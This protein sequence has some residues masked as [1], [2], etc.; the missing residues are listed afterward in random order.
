MFMQRTRRFGLLAAVIPTLLTLVFMTGCSRDPNVRKQKYL[1]SGKRYEDAGKLKEAQI[2]FL[3]ALKVDHNFGD[4]HYELAKIYLKTGSIKEGYGELM[5]AVDLSPGNLQARIDLGNLLLAGNVLDRANQ[6]A[7]AVLAADPNNAD[8]YA[9]RSAIDARQG[10]HA[11][12][13]ADIQHALSIKPNQASYHTTLALIEASDP[14]AG[15]L[16]SAQQELQKS[17][18]LDPKDVHARM[19][20]ASLMEKKGDKAGAEQQYL[21]TIQVTPKDYQ[22]RAALAGMYLR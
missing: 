16:D 4:A 5:H 2:Q 3:N 20:L 9:L 1:A 14:G 6:Q 18:T 11:E 12:A 19:L 17:V 13:L 21:A 7:T 8:A 10:K 22:P 15:N